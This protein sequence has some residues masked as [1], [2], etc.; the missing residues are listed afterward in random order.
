MAV[1]Y[2]ITN[3]ENG[4]IYV[5]QTVQFEKRMKQHQHS[6]KTGVDAAIKKYG[7]ENF[8]VEILEECPEEMLD[9]RE[10]FWIAKLNSMFP[11]GYNLTSGG[12]R[13]KFVSAESIAKMSAKLK[14]RFAGEQNPFYG[15]HHTEE[16]KAK[17][18]AAHRGTHHTAETRA[19]MSA[20]QSGENNAFYGKQHSE[21]FKFQKSLSKKKIIYP[22]FEKELERRFL[23][24]KKLAELMGVN[25][26]SFTDSLSDRKK[27][28]LKTA[29]KIRDFL[30]V[31]MTIEELFARNENF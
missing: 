26:D 29:E 1:I 15:K 21:E 22:V 14:G 20:K 8:S 23:T 31:D 13:K 18:G 5:G 25:Y 6:K 12:E 7:W 11:N 30:G 2:K 28:S 27:L 16:A 9:E 10:I 17:N 4:K 24:R 19:K 3:L